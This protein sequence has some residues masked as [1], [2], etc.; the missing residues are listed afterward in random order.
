M[1]AQNAKKTKI[2]LNQTNQDSQLSWFF[3][4]IRKTIRKSKT[5]GSRELFLPENDIQKKFSKKTIQILEAWKPTGDMKFNDLIFFAH[6]LLHMN[7][8]V[9]IVLGT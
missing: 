3:Q 1:V 6:A 5:R 8:N 2:T 7:S 9:K 4:I